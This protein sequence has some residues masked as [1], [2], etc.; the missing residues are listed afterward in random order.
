MPFRRDPNG[1]LGFSFA[2]PPGLF[3]FSGV[4]DAQ[5]FDWDDLYTDLFD[6]GNSGQRTGPWDFK[7][8]PSNALVPSYWVEVDGRRLGLWYFQ[9]VS[10]D[11]LTARR[12]RGRFAFRLE[13]GGGHA[14]TLAPYNHPEAKWLSAQLDP[15]PV[16]QLRPV[17]RAL[18][19]GPGDAVTAWG[20]PGFW[21]EQRTRLAYAPPA[22]PDSL[23]HALDWSLSRT[24][25]EDP[26]AAN[27][28]D[29]PLLAAAW[30]LSA[31]ADARDCA[32]SLVDEAVRLE[33]WGN[34]RPDGYGHNGDMGAALV[35]RAMAWA[36]QMLREEL[37]EELRTRLLDKLRLQG[38][39]F[40][41]LALL[42]RD[43][44][45]GSI[46][47]D[48]G[49]RSMWTF[50]TAALNLYG[51]LPRAESWLEFLLPRLK[52]CTDAMPRDGYIPP[53]SYHSTYLYLEEL[54]LC[55][56]TL[57]ALGGPDV[58]EWGPFEEIPRFVRSSLR[59][60][61]RECLTDT[62][63]GL[64]TLAGGLS[65]FSHMATTKGDAH[66]AR[67]LSLLLAK[68]EQPHHRENLGAQ[69][70]HS[71]FWFFFA[72]DF[73]Q[74]P[75]PAAPDVPVRRLVYLADSA[76]V[77]FR[78]DELDV[79]LSLQCGPWCG[80]HAERH[81]PD[82][83]DRMLMRVAAG[84]FRFA[85]AGQDM[86]THA[87]TG[88]SLHTG[89][90]SVLLIDYRGQ[91][92]D[93]NYPMSIP[94]Q[95]HRGEEIRRVQWDEESG[96]GM[97]RLDLAA[98]YPE[99]AGLIRYWRDF[100][101]RPGR[102]LVVRDR[103]LLDRARQLSWLFQADERRGLSLDGLTARLAGPPQMTIRPVADS[104]ELGAAVRRTY[105]VY[106]YSSSRPVF[107]HFRYDTRQPVADACIDF[108]MEW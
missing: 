105:Q 10:L 100:L 107:H 34:P 72:G 82:P 95:P 43:Y 5:Q 70:H 38:D 68:A 81:A 86:V 104:M 61:D 23:T 101:I 20:V 39:R 93:V 24:P 65:F 77:H 80:Y 56:W 6:Y 15:D 40:I 76:L 4:I 21:D 106:A 57:L 12:F 52:R 32:V 90:G 49:W 13:T 67:L 58:Y 9:R 27:R 79:A 42:N 55:R 11:D 91:V 26:R 88:Y 103:L 64:V 36:V 96:A 2:A 59:R 89:A 25:G 18:R 75:L 69:H 8:G 7:L 31:N 73:P 102:E 84:D 45:G 71:R 14:V 97:V 33:H 41:D 62:D 66:S 28:L 87:D 94:S 74:A 54:S 22:V 63:T 51:V 19:P 17:P 35:M 47:Q 108:V 83:C 48:H 1:T 85:L 53:S 44:W 92:G 60:Q 50:G 29:I 78:D 99:D 37:G 16:D 46:L 3:Q 30:G 98:A